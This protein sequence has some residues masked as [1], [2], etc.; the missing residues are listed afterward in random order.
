MYCIY[1]DTDVAEADGNY[2]HIVALSLGG[3]NGFCVWSDKKFNSDLG[4][5]IDGALA[6]DGLCSRVAAPT[7]GDIQEKSRF[8]FGQKPPLRAVLSKF[9]LERR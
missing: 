4:H 6:N 3:D 8:R 9:P 5:K 1:T 2:D 7:R